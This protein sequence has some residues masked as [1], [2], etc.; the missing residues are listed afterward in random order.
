MYYEF[1]VSLGGR[2]LFATAERSCQDSSKAKQLAHTLYSKFPESEGYSVTC[3]RYE[4]SSTRIAAVD[5][6]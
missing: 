3:T 4:T 1:N 6:L 5:L 2:H